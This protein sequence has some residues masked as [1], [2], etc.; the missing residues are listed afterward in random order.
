MVLAAAQWSGPAGAPVA[1]HSHLPAVAPQTV[2]R[3][4]SWSTGNARTGSLCVGSNSYNA[5]DFSERTYGPALQ[6]F[7]ETVR[8]AHPETP[9]VVIMPLL[10]PQLAAFLH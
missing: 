1:A 3:T 8:S 4:T 6:W 5:A 2:R 7:L 9:L 10:S